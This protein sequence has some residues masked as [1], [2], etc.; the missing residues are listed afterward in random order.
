MAKKT[1]QTKQGLVDKIIEFLE[2]LED[3]ITLKKALRNREKGRDLRE[4]AKELGLF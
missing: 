3:R 2:D 1:K 4:V